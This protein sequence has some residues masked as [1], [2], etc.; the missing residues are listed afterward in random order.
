LQRLFHR[1][2]PLAGVAGYDR[3]RRVDDGRAQRAGEQRHEILEGMDAIFV[4]ELAAGDGHVGLRRLLQ[5][6]GGRRELLV[7]GADVVEQRPVRALRIAHVED[8]DQAV[9]GGGVGVV[10]DGEPP[11]ALQLELLG[12]RID[13]GSDTLRGGSQGIRYAIDAEMG[14]RCG[15]AR[16][17]VW[18]YTKYPN[19][20]SILRSCRLSV[21][22]VRTRSLM[23]SLEIE[24]RGWSSER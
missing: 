22:M 14:I 1:V 10:D 21:A 24:A 18:K 2:G 12:R 19:R 16:A 9:V 13:Q 6:A 11:G 4:V 8:L 3:G 20:P 17:E 7:H 5:V 23:P 15:P